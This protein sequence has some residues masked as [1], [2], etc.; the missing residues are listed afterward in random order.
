[1]PRRQNTPRPQ[2]SADANAPENWSDDAPIVPDEAPVTASTMLLRGDAPEEERTRLKQEVEQ[3]DRAL[4]I[5]PKCKAMLDVSACSPL[6]QTACPVCGSSVLVLREFQDFSLLGQIGR[7]GFGNVYRAFDRNLQRDLA[8]KLL[9]NEFTSQASYVERL[10]QEGQIMASMSHPHVVKVFSAGRENGFCHIAMELVTGGSFAQKVDRGRQPEAAILEMGI[11]VASALAAC[12]ERGLLHRD[13]KPGNILFTSEG[14]AK[15]VDFGLSLTLEQAQDMSGDVWGTPQYIAPEK[16]LRE[17]EDVRSE[18]Y[19]LGCTLYHGLAGRPPFE[20]QTHA[21]TVQMQISKPPPPLVTFAPDISQATAYVINKCL[22]KKPANRYQSYSELM[23]NLEYALGKCSKG[24]ASPK[25]RGAGSKGITAGKA[26]LVGAVAAA[27][28]LGGLW[29]ANFGGSSAKVKKPA[30]GQASQPLVSSIQDAACAPAR[31]LLANGNYAAAAAQF[32]RLRE[33]AATTDAHWDLG[34]CEGIALLGAGETARAKAFF[35]ALPDTSRGENSPKTALFY[36]VAQIGSGDA[37][38]QK[39]SWS[40]LPEDA[41][42]QL[43]RL[44]LG[45]IA[46][47][48]D[49]FGPAAELFQAFAENTGKVPDDWSSTCAPAAASFLN[50]CHDGLAHGRQLPLVWL[51]A[52]KD[53]ID[54]KTG[55]W[56]NRGMAGGSATQGE[57]TPVF[58]ETGMLGHPCLQFSA[59]NHANYSV[60]P[61]V[62]DDFTIFCVY[63]TKSGSG[64]GKGF[65]EGIA[66]V[67]A[68]TEGTVKDFGVS[69]SADGM[70]MAGTGDPDLTIYSRGGHNEGLPHVLA[71]SREKENGRM[72]ISIDGRPPTVG[73]GSAD[74]LTAPNRIGIGQTSYGTGQLDGSIGEVR[75]YAEALSDAALMEQAKQLMAKFGIPL[76]RLSP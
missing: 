19:S 66:L 41:S 14:A 26:A 5:C 30:A 13:I 42:G 45:F 56:L 55:A 37:P 52:E 20:G 8:V 4:E 22:E 39:E 62:R 24:S 1:M 60:P 49:C 34:M 7:G 59:S 61:L 51:R 54:P 6:T 27:V 47:R 76:N 57:N 23:E 73:K 67:S 46:F 9:R 75:I 69:I 53:S 2:S 58:S 32:H 36:Q 50:L 15:V 25:A 3:Q 43:A 64:E 48:R 11:Q 35:A 40:H 74:S 21:A 72:A 29:Y 10:E 18:I 16:L 68:E 33:A 17:G 12:A 31:L 28:V 70:L 65:Y 63:S 38:L 71:F 44:A